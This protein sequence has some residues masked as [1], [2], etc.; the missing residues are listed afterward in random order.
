MRLTY[1]DISVK[2][3]EKNKPNR[4]VV[5]VSGTYLKT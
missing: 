4:H 1:V 5:R 3:L 2:D